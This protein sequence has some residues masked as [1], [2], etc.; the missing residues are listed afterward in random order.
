MTRVNV[1]HLT[2][3]ATFLL[4]FG[5]VTQ[6]NLLIN[7]GFEIGMTEPNDW[8]SWGPGGTINWQT[9]GAHTGSRCMDLGGLS[10]ALVYQ[11]VPG[12][13]G[14]SYITKAWAKLNSGAGAAEL[15][16]EFHNSSEI[17]IEEHKLNLTATGTW[18]QYSIDGT[19]PPDTYYVTATVVGL[20]GGMVLFD[21]VSLEVLPKTTISS[22]DPNILYTG[23]INFDDPNTPVLDWPGTSL[24]A[25]FE[26]TSVTA[27]LDDSGD[28]YFNAII[29][30]NDA[31]M[32]VLDC[33]P[34]LSYYK[35]ASG[36]SD[37]VH[38]IQINKRTESLQT[39]VTFNGFK[40]DESRSL[41]ARPSR[42]INKIEYYGD[43]IT[44]GNAVDDPIGGVPNKNNYLTYAGVTARNLDAEYHCIAISGIGLQQSVI[45]GTIFDY[46]DKELGYYSP[47]SP[48][49]FSKWIPDAVVINLGQNDYTL[50]SDPNVTD[51]YVDFMLDIR[52]EYPDTHIFLVLGDM[53]AVEPN[54][55]YPGYQQSAVDTMINTYGDTKVYQLTFDYGGTTHPTVARHEAM[56]DVL[57]EFILDNVPG[58]LPPLDGDANGDYDVDYEDFALVSNRWQDT[59]CGTCD[60]ADLSGDGNVTMEDVKILANNW[61]DDW[62]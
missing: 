15:K 29:D 11:R 16:L 39:S 55:P 3:L 49:D 7:P 56:A 5:Q 37:T 24:V 36:L 13:V 4:V 1:A 51:L 23:R 58:L 41:V 52:A 31:N 19:A 40:L 20:S 17:P 12:I 62:H 6:A 60:G 47:V 54:S 27:I 30:D 34:G 26:G 48:W 45:T 8:D 53:T 18:L 10:L 25:N 59:N 61:F 14:E 46:Y 22:N 42:P 38:K 2:F 21:D 35:I 9:G 28:N 33:V 57:T 32:I 44:V 43:S 50:G